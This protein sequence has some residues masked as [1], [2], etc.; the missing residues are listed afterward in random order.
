MIKITDENLFLSDT[1]RD[2]FQ[3]IL[4]PLIRIKTL[5][6][7]IKMNFNETPLRFANYTL[8]YD[9]LSTFNCRHF[10]STME[11]F[12][13]APD[14]FNTSLDELVMFLAQVSFI[15]FLYLVIF[16]EGKSFKSVS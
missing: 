6:I 16:L 3:F 14:K 2:L 1:K 15:S 5:L 12:D 4:Y 11:V 7:L 13:L 9:I 8:S 10:Q